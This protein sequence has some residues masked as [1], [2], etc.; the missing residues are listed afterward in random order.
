MFGSKY[1]KRLDIMTVVAMSLA[2]QKE[3]VPEGVSWVMACDLYEKPLS[4]D[5]ELKEFHKAMHNITQYAQK[6]SK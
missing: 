1:K 4:T 6:L 3:G 5:E 2:L